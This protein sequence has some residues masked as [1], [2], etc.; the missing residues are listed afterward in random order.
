MS[1]LQT[2]NNAKSTSTELNNTDDPVTFDVEGGHGARFPDTADGPFRVTVWS[3]AYADPADDTDMEIMEVTSRSTDSFTATRA[4]EG[5]SKVAHSG[6]VNVALLNTSGLR[7]EIITATRVEHNDDGTHKSATVTTLKATGAEINTGTADDK[8][9][10]PKAIADS[11]IMRQV[12][13]WI[14]A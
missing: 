11:T 8:I 7:E 2:A 6:T 12:D 10:T 3:T 1:F 5:T 13:G 4:R 9:V 14:E